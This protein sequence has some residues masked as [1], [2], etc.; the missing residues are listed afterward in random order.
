MTSSISHEPR[1]VLSRRRWLA[2]AMIPVWAQ[3]THDTAGGGQA[4]ASAADV[5][6][7][8]TFGDSVLDCGHYNDR[9]I[10]PGQLMVRND[11]ALFPEFKGHDLQ[12]RGPAR[13]QHRA[14]DG[15]TVG[16]LKAQLPGRTVDGRSLALLT[17]GGNDFLRGLASD[18][19]S[20]LLAFEKTLRAFLVALPVRPVLLGTVYDPTFGDDSRN[21]LGVPAALARANHRR[22][23]EVISSAAQDYG[24]LVDLHAHFLRGAPSWFTRTIEP[25]LTGASEIRRA[26]LQAL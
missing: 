1:A 26:F 7:L 13:L 24:R 16:G 14:K 20:G 23:N 10:T 5:L 17:V 19:G 11:D 2:I 4:T 6:T 22:V 8:W 15:A 25:S 21:F 9:G 18:R 12:S 3:A